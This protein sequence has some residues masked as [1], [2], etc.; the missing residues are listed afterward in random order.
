M[1]I[2]YED[3]LYESA[4]NFSNKQKIKAEYNHSRV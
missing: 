3:I 1:G 4:I 2:K